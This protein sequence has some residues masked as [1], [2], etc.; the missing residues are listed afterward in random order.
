LENL[1]KENEINLRTLFEAGVHFG[2][3]TRKWNPKMDNFIFTKKSKSHVIDLEKTL[4]QL[5]KARKLL[6]DIISDGGQ[7]MFVG[8]KLQAS[9]TI[10]EEAARSESLYV[11]QRWLGGMLTNFSTMKSRVDTLKT[12]ESTVS[13]ADNKTNTKKELQVLAT[14]AKKLKKVATDKILLKVDNISRDYQDSSFKFFG[15]RSSFN[16]VRNVSFSINYNENVGLVGES[17]CGKSTITR[18]ILGLDPISNGKIFLEN[19][20]IR[21][22]KVDNKIRKKVQVVFQDP[23]GSF[24]P[25]HNV[26]KLVSEPLY[27]EN[28]KTSDTQKLDMVKELLQRVG[29]KPSDYKKFIHEFSGGQRQRIA[30]ARSLILKPKLIIL[31]EAVSALDVSIRAQILDLLVELSESFGLSYLFISHDLSLVKSITSRVLVMRSGE[32][33]EAGNT[34][35]IFNSPSHQYT[36]NLLE[37]SPNLENAIKNL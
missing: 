32:I 29:L 9:A 26:L 5:Q 27:L 22:E 16:A 14:K 25:R 21:S 37:S 31:D 19:D 2:H 23:F 18:A 4:E 30:I 10:K 13:Q 15:K 34:K 1:L 6:I 11:N 36:K 33:V 24:N 3:P 7:C 35:E 20:E 8:T 28:L 17:G 12:I